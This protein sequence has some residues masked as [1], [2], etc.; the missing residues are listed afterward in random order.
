MNTP[1]IIDTCTWVLSLSKNY[2]CHLPLLLHCACG[3][4]AEMA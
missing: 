4:S 1:I 2:I 3:Q